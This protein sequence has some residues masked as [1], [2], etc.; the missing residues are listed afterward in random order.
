MG[1]IVRFPPPHA[2]GPDWEAYD[3]LCPDCE[4]PLGACRDNVGRPW[5][6]CERCEEYVDLLDWP[7][8]SA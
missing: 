5:G 1:D 4:T 3:V 8:D 7:E 6:W 2:G